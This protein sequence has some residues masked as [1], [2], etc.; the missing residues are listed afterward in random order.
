MRTGSGNGYAIVNSE[1]SMLACGDAPT[2][3][4]FG[5]SGMNATGA[6]AAFG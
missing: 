5:G 2:Y 1:G 6:A 4:S 3:E